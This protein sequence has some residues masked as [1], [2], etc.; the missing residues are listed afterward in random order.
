[1][2][3]SHN[4]P[5]PA[6]PSAKAFTVT[7]LLVAVSLMSLIVLALYAMFNQ[8]QRALRSNEAQ[9]DSTERGR[10]VLELVSRE[11]ESARVSMRPGVTNLWI[12]VAQGTR[13]Q[14]ED[15][16]PTTNAVPQEVRSNKF[17]N[18]YYQAKADKAWRGVGYAILQSTNFGLQEVLAPGINALGTLYRYETR[19]PERE[20]YFP[21]TNLFRGF[22]NILPLVTATPGQWPAA[23][24]F[25]QVA[26]GI[27]HFKVLPFDTHG[28]LMAFAT[29]NLVSGS[30]L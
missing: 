29:T 22:L 15:N 6:R 9:V 23:S 11:F 16:L 5:A 12:R 10:G 13:N 25:S 8:T 4:Q 2:F 26:D 30:T 1:M 20:F 19:P 24:N 28:R 27:V 3:L 14:Q 21:T 18:V 17:D 7:E